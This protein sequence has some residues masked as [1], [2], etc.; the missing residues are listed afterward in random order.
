[1]SSPA[2]IKCNIQWSKTVPLCYYSGFYLC[3]NCLD[4]IKAKE[5]EETRKRILEA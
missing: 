3:G 5:R 4:K 2:C 1:M